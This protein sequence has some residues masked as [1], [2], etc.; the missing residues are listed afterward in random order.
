MAGEMAKKPIP[1]A[2][3]NIE[4]TPNSRG[5]SAG[6]ATMSNPSR[7]AEMLRQIGEIGVDP[8]AGISRIGFSQEERRAHKLVAGWLKDLGLEVHS[9][10][11]G[12]TIACRAGTSRTSAAIGFGSHLDSVSHGGRF[13]GIAGVVAMVEVM[14]LMAERST[15]TS[16]PLNGLIFACEEGGRFGEPCIGSKA[17]A[18]MLKDSDLT[19]IRDVQGVTLEQAMV[20]V[21][22][23]PTRLHEVRWDRSEIAAFLEV[24]I[25]QGRTLETENRSIG[26]VDVVSGSTRMRTVVTGRAGHTGGTRMQD[27]ADALPAAAEITLAVEAMANEASYRGA[28]ATVGC[29]DVYPNRITTIPGRVEMRIDIRDFDSD[30]LRRAAREIADRART[31]CERRGVSLAAEV[32]ADTS[33]VVLS[34]WLR[35]SV[36]EVCDALGTDYRFMPS[37]AGHDAQIMASIAPAAIIFVPSKDGASHVPE[38]WTSVADIAKGIDVLYQSIVRID[39]VLASVPLSQ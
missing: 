39:Q 15:A 24:H 35:K 22:L 21:G 2:S 14:H 13:D 1:R 28:R 17:I 12:N 33:P 4:E 37:G 20:G 3:E 10:A 34:M 36:S 32:I 23:E 7:V 8:I 5:A 19:R 29:L 38:E 26:L 31:I 25:E 6:L 30:R 18:G 16:H 9:D 27:R 11:V